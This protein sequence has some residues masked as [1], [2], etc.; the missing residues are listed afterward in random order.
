MNYFTLAGGADGG[1]NSS[2]IKS[3]ALWKTRLQN[4]ELA[5][6]TSI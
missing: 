4:A 5:T 1:A 3:S 2:N 6:L